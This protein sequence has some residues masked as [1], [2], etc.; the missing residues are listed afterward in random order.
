[1]RPATLVRLALAGT[2]TDTARVVLT[3][4][5]AL[6]ATLAGLAALTVLAIQKPA[7]RRLG[8]SPSSTATRCCASPGCAAGR[9]SRCCMLDDPGAGAGRAVRP[10]RRAGP[11]PPAG[12][13]P[14]GRRHARAGDPAGRAGDRRGRLLGTLAGLGVYLVGREL[15]HRPDAQGRLALPTDVLPSTGAWPAVVLRPAGARG[16]GHRADAAHGHHE[17]ARGAPQAARERGPGPWAGLA[18]RAGLVSFAL[19][20]PVGLPASAGRRR[21]DRL[22][23]AAAVRGGRAR[24][25]GRGGA[26]HRLDLVHLRAAAAPARPRAGGAARGGPADGRPVGGQP[27]VRGA[28]RRRDLRRGR[29]RRCG[30]TSPPQDQLDREQN[31][32]AGRGRRRR[33]A[34][35]CPPWIWSMPRSGWPSLIA[36]GGLMVALVEGIVARRRAYAALVATGVPR[37]TLSRSV[38]GRRWRRRCRRS[39]WRSPWARRSVQGSVA[40]V[41]TGVFRRDLRGHGSAL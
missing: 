41:P 7:R 25:D 27:H 3:A 15:L 4:L 21:A 39:C 19:I 6:L 32:L 18:D 1:M 12:R 2:R 13:D 37:A 36:A 5:S 30:P 11:G 28:A 24:G 26:R 20:R 22:A 17:P 9:R 38:P 31:R 35:I 34:S 23:G 40:E 16:A 33:P 10:A 8:R 14:A 29:G